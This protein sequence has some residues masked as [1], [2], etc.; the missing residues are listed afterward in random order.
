MVIDLA[1]LIDIVIF[2]NARVYL[3]CKSMGITK[4]VP[5]FNSN[6]IFHSGNYVMC[7]IRKVRDYD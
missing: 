3:L 6:L 7:D 1:G 4:F 5:H 2:H